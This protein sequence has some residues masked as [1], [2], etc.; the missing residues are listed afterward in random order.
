[1]AS[2]DGSDNAENLER[3]A[4][5]LEELVQVGKRI[6]YAIEELTIRSSGD[7]RAEPCSNCG[8]Q[9]MPDIRRR[10][11]EEPTPVECPAC[12]DVS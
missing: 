7:L 6:A 9:L 4:L 10:D 1:M 12:G 5:G 3:I 2:E 11:D 8:S